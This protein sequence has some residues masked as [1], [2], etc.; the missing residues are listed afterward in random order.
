MRR[1]PIFLVIDVSES[2]V[3]S[4]LRH[5]QEGIN[6]LIN[7]LR[8][9]PYALETVY[10]SVIAFAGVVKNACAVD[11]IVCVLSAAFACGC[12]DFVGGGVESCNG[13]DNAKSDFK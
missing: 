8:K 12:G 9:D 3:G 7:E 10:L 4:P 13:R 11:G 6:Q 5:M 2:M 1:L